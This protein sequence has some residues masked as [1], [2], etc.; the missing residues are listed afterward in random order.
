LKQISGLFDPEKTDVVQLTKSYRS[1]KELTNFT[2]QILRQGEKIEAFNR[3]G[4]KPI[5]WGRKTDDEAIDVLVNVLHNNEQ[6]KRTTAVI[7]KD[8][9]AAK[10]L[11]IT[12]VVR[13]FC[14]LLCKTLTKTSIASSS[15]FL[16][17]IIG[18][19]PL[20]LKASIFSP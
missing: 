17:Q 20:R 6:N 4:P 12:A 19:G 3:K 2:K 14:S 13:L 9:A 5:I 16:P 18:L 7:T 15:V 1:T 8:L 10:S 11:V